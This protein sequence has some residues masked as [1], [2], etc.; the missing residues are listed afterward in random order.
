M[1][2][3]TRLNTVIPE[4]LF[5]QV[6]IVDVRKCVGTSNPTAYKTIW[7]MHMGTPKIFIQ[8]RGWIHRD[9]DIKL[10][11]PQFPSYMSP[12]GEKD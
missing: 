5:S 8:I 12:F 2:F 9:E 10:C 1:Y 4:Q 3:G 7:D 11:V 6:H